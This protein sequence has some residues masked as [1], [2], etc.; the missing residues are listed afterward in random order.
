MVTR[1]GES[2]Q[3]SGAV[4]T[5]SAAADLFPVVERLTHAH[6]NQVETARAESGRRLSGQIASQ[7]HHLLLDLG[8]LRLRTSPPRAVAQKRHAMAHPTWEERQKV[9]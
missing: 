6:E 1:R 9:R 4:K 7:M 5:S 2:P 8:E 3:P